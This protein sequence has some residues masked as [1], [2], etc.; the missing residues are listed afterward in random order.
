[1]LR[2]GTVRLR[3]NDGNLL[4]TNHFGSA[5]KSSLTRPTG[6][7]CKKPSRPSDPA[8]ASRLSRSDRGSTDGR[9]LAGQISF[10]LISAPLSDVAD[11]RR[12]RDFQSPRPRRTVIPIDSPGPA[13]DA[14][15][16]Q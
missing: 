2:L 16:D 15:L 14:V 9:M 7:R 13:A 1:M 8:V 12:L 4:G 5:E 11:G 10:I 3:E 6:I